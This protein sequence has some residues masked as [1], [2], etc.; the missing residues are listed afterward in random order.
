MAQFYHPTTSCCLL[1]WEGLLELCWKPSDKKPW[2]MFTRC[3]EQERARGRDRE[4]VTGMKRKMQEK[5]YFSSHRYKKTIHQCRGLHLWTGWHAVMWR[6][7]VDQPMRT[8]PLRD[9]CHMWVAVGQW[10]SDQSVRAKQMRGGKIVILVFLAPDESDPSQRIGMLDTRH[11]SKA[12][13]GEPWWSH[14]L[15]W[16]L[17]TTLA[18]CVGKLAFREGVGEGGVKRK[19]L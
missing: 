9:M 7:A 1:S 15:R 12:Q 2:L 18:S 6:K 19:V 13:E 8:H 10:K 5:T 3:W 17:G 14:S 4:G 16:S 11:G